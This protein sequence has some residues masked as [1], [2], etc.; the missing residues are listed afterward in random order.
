MMGRTVSKFVPAEELLVSYNATSLEDTDTIIHV[1]KISENDLRKQQV[2]GFYKDMDLG[3]PG[4]ES[5]DIENK[6]EEIEGVEKANGNE[7]HTLLECHC[8][9]EIE[10][11]ED[12]DEQG[13]ETGI[14]RP[15]IVTLHE[16]SGE[17]LAIR[18]NYGPMDPL[19]RKKEYF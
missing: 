8:E 5:S 4:Y 11:F 14:K 2:A 6:K 7:V 9:L 3:D 12:K 13:M 17:V 1:I 18:R 19:K 15:Y 16:D 10:G